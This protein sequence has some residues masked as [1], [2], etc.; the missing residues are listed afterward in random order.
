MLDAV[1]HRIK[2]GLGV[3]AYARYCDDMVVFGRSPGELAGVRAEID[4]A[5]RRLRLVAHPHKTQVVPTAQ[6]VPWVGFVVYPQRIGMRREA[7]RR[8]RR[9]LRGGGG[10]GGD[11]ERWRAVVA[12]LRGHARYGISSGR[13]AAW[14]GGVG[15][16]EVM[17]A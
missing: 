12:S 9:R 10:S 17:E 7:L 1:D 15:A 14:L 11:G 3:R 8:L 13:L 6:G 5:L 4:A 2:D 16:G